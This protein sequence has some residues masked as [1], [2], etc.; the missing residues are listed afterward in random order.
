MIISFPIE[1]KSISELNANYSISIVIIVLFIV[2]V[3]KGDQCLVIIIHYYF[4]QRLDANREEKV[5]D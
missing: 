1:L 2:L 3:V 4:L 5:L